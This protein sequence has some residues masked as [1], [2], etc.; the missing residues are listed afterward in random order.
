MD[1]WYP[2]HSAQETDADVREETEDGS[3]ALLDAREYSDESDGGSWEDEEVPD[4]TTEDE[5][6]PDSSGQYFPWGSKQV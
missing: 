6:L 3:E 2:A 4:E 5:V 1:M